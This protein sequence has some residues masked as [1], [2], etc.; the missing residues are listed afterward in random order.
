MAFG[1]VAF[2]TAGWVLAGELVHDVPPLTVA[3]LRTGSTFVVI[4]ALVL[5]RRPLRRPA[6]VAAGRWPAVL[7]LAALGF[8]IYY[9]ATM[10]GITRIGAPATSIVVG[11]LPCVTLLIGL[12]FYHERIGGL[13]VLGTVLAVAAAATY[14]LSHGDPVQADRGAGTLASGVALAAVGTIA[15]SWYGY[16]YRRSMGD[17]PS[18]ASLP[19]ITGAATLGLLPLV[20]THPDGWALSGRQVLGVVLLGVVFTAPVFLLSHELVLVRGPLF[21]NSVAVCVPFL[22]RATQWALGVAEPFAIW[23]L[24][25]FALAAVGV[26]LAVRA[27]HPGADQPRADQ[28]RAGATQP[29]SAPPGSDSAPTSVPT[30]APGRQP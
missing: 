1:L 2:L 20:W 6:R 4:T 30:P 17:L 12:A 29:D 7:A 26:L 25:L 9:S 8:L 14:G 22:T 11:L 28:P 23:E 16:H 5:A 27:Q 19:A 3:A 24:F 13:R 18:L 21:T 15:Y 10:L